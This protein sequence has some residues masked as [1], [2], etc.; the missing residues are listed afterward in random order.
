MADRIPLI[1]DTSDGNKIKELPVG[2]N[3][4]LSNSSLVNV[5]SVTATS[6]NVGGNLFTGSYADLTNTPTIPTDISDLTDTQSLLGAG[7]GG[8]TII[9]GGG[10]GRWMLTADDSTQVDILSDN[11]VKI[12]GAGN[13]TTA[14]SDVSGTTVLTVTGTESIRWDSGSGLF[15]LFTGVDWIPIIDTTYTFEAGD[16]DDATAKKIRLTGTGQSTQ[17]VTVR[18]GTG[19]TITRTSNELTFTATDTDTTY[20]I[21]AAEDGN[22][23]A[24]LRLTASSLLTDD[25]IFAPGSGIGIAKTDDNTLTI[26][27]TAAGAN[28]FGTVTV[29]VTDIVAD[30]T[31]DTLTI[32]GGANIDVTGD[33]GTD[34]ITIANT[35]ADQNLFNQVAGD[36]GSRIAQTT[37]ETLTIAGGT[38]VTTT[39]AGSTVTIDATGGG[40]SQNVFG[41]IAV[42]GQSNVVA[43][44]TTD[45]LTLVAGTGITLTTNPT[46]DSIT[47]TN[48]STGSS[49]NLFQTV[50]VSGQNNIVAD[51]ATDT[52]TFVGGSGITLTTNSTTDAV[53]I[54]NADPNVDQNIFQSIA[55]SG[56]GNVVADSTT[57]TLTFVAGSNMTITTDVATDTVTFASSGGGGS[58]NVFDKIA[59]SGE[60]DVVADSTTDTLTFVAGAGIGIT[61]TP[62]TDSVTISASGG[63]GSQS[64]F[65]TIAVSGQ[66]DVVADTTTDTLTFVAGTNMTIT[67]DAG[68]DTVT[69]DSSGGGGSQDLFKTITVAGQ[70]DVVAD[71]TADVLTFVAGTD[72]S[73]TTNQAADSITINS[74]GSGGEDNEFSFKTIEVSGQSD[75]VA[76][77]TTDTLTFIEGS[78]MTITTSGDSITFA[79]TGGGG[80]Q[81]LWATVA[82]DTGSTTA[83]T[84]TDTL[85]IVGGTDISTS[86]VADLLTINYTGGASA[87]NLFSTIAI[88]GQNSIVAD[89]PTDTLT[90]AS[91][92]G[93]VLV[94]TAATDTLTI[95][96][97]APNIVQDVFSEIAVSGQSSLFADSSADTLNVA[98]GAGIEVTTSAG[99]DTLTITNTAPNVVQ[100]LW[101]QISSDS[102]STTAN[103]STDALAILGGTDISTSVSGDTLT[104]AYT[105]SS[106]SNQNLWYTIDSDSGSTTAN[107]TTDTL[108]IAG[109]TSIGTS[110]SGDTLTITNQAPNVD[111]N[112][113]NT[114]AV[115]GQSDVIADTTTDTLTFVAG[116]NITITTDAGTDSIT[117]NSTGGGGSGTPGG[118]T[119]EV[120]YNDGGSFAGDSDLTWNSGTNTLSA[121]NIIAETVETETIEAP[122]NL[123]GTYTISSPTTITL[124]PVSEVILD[125][126]IK[127]LGKTAA[128]L[129]TFTAS[130]GT[131]VAVSDNSYK[132]AYYDGS[133]WKYV[134]TDGGV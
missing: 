104:I 30:T 121:K 24:V 134:A 67:T 133:N 62:G 93:I 91:G 35:H 85:G 118:S 7:G 6:V 63:A 50:A 79:S 2:D 55:V 66:S 111:Q 131:I 125:A 87:Q 117:I 76:D 11:T 28:A 119:T 9:S 81:N 22:T 100:S 48:S 68:T 21:S 122:S 25:V 13:I 123:V 53:T 106:G 127:L 83:N 56:Q 115:S 17:D 69:F 99:T 8:T 130:A 75:V 26:S 92:A 33:A 116:S 88:A 73:I 109:G 86:I 78:N 42:S 132:P 52:L 128:Q 98:E 54:V 126:P 44:S 108:S 59:V 101:S 32:V 29:G 15:E 38:N 43:D 74:T 129:A 84:T 23:N 77:T 61:T 72:I 103:T 3:L 95:A 39:V 110:V 65:E 64:L 80:S 107:S 96:N 36:T 34:T 58:Q 51:S 12:A 90:L 4:D 27:N 47:V 102:G 40:G 5:T 41:V 113:F 18:E 57:D 10:A 97:S 49:Q 37:T 114:I 82:G 105:G 112:L 70:D 94:T 31:N 71:S 20:S 60:T 45:T 124:D 19:V 14:T 120:Q 16:G 46:N 1:V 89:A